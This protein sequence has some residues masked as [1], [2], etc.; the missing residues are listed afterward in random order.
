[1][2]YIEAEA[3]AWANVVEALRGYLQMQVEYCE[4]RSGGIEEMATAIADDVRFV[5][6][7]D[8]LPEA[9]QDARGMLYTGDNQPEGSMT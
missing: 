8:L 4:L 1:M 9:M 5:M 7:D 2:G 3:Q 6:L